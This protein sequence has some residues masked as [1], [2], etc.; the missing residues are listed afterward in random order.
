ML[1]ASDG[2]G[3]AFAGKYLYFVFRT[4]RNRNADLLQLVDDDLHYFVHVLE[5]FLARVGPG[6]GAVQLK[7][8]AIRVPPIIVG[9]HDDFERVGL[10]RHYY[11]AA[12]GLLSA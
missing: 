9:F 6:G 10:H 2:Y 7:R 5:S 11:A 4:G 8:G 12:Y 1:I 3:E